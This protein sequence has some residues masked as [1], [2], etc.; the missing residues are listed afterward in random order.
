LTCRKHLEG[1]T[2]DGKTMS[3]VNCERRRPATPLELLG[4]RMKR[5]RE[6]AILQ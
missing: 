3:C 1:M 5:S 2:I 4:E 6:Q